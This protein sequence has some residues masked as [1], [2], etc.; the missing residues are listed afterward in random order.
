MDNSA[1]ME[2]LK[3][4]FAECDVDNNGCLGRDEFSELCSK[5]GLNKEAAHE[6]FARLDI[7]RD[8]K[9]TFDEFAAGFNQYKSSSSSSSSPQPP[10]AATAAAGNNSPP[11]PQSRFAGGQPQQFIKKPP[12][13]ASSSRQKG[14][15]PVSVMSLGSTS[16]AAATAAATA[17][18]T[19]GNN[20][21]N[22]SNNNLLGLAAAKTV[23]SAGGSSGAS[24]DMS[25]SFNGTTGGSVDTTTHS[26]SLYSAPSSS[27]D[28][29]QQQRPPD[30][31]SMVVYSSE[32][33]GN[34]YYD[35]P[36]A[37]HSGQFG[38]LFGCGGGGGG[39][40]SL[41]GASSGSF[42]QVRNMQELLDCVQKL[43]SENQILTQIF[44]KDKREREEYISQLGEEFDQQVREVEE[45]A[46]RRAREELE[47]EKKRLRE[48]MQTE[49][50]TLQHHYKT[51]EKMSKLIQNPSS[52]RSSNDL[53][54]GGEG[55]DKVKSKLEDTYLENRQLKRSLLDTKT[56]VAMIWKEMEK[57]KSQYEDKLSSAY[58]K[59]NETRSE[60]DHIKQQLNLMKDSNR[61]LQDASDVITT[62]I[63]D[64]VDPV[65]K[66]ASAAGA[67]SE[68]EHYL[69]SPNGCHSL[70]GG[71]TSGASQS[72]SRRGSVL[73]EYL[74]SHPASSESDEDDDNDND[75]DGD[76]EGDD[77]DENDKGRRFGSK[78]QQQ[79]RRGELA[80]IPGGNPD[81]TEYDARS[82]TASS[83]MRTSGG[84]PKISLPA[85]GSEQQLNDAAAGR[86]MKKSS[87]FNPLTSS[88]EAAAGKSREDAGRKT[89][90]TPEPESEAT[91]EAARAKLQTS[92]SQMETLSTSSSRGSSLKNLG[93]HFFL[94]SKDKLAGCASTGQS[95]SGQSDS[96]LTPKA[97]S[98]SLDQR[99]ALEPV[100]EPADGPS[101]STF[102]II[103]VG[104]SFVGK[105]SFAARFMEGNFVQG[106]ISNC[107]IDFKTK[108][109]K[110]DG[111]NY[112]VNLWDTAGQERFRSI[113]ASYFRKADGIIL[114]YDVTD[115]R[116]YLNVRNWMSTISDTAA[117]N[118][119]VLLVGNKIDLRL[120]KNKD[121]CVPHAE[122]FRLAK[123]YDI[124]FLET[125]VKT[126][127]NLVP[128]MGR[129]I[130]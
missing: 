17:T 123:E 39:G 93:R 73:S 44:F 10:A 84:L 37:G 14:A 28:H 68:S 20:S 43:Q 46:N 63:T 117:E 80:T 45:R 126:G 112:T 41:N 25:D 50:E 57:L 33:T 109:Y 79:Q 58:L 82:T 99:D 127:T 36:T 75:D 60:C 83:S 38:S 122:G 94:G 95:Q 19:S 125:S 24:A 51:I 2:N 35:Q 118:V 90:N 97:K 40:G 21:S 100:V 5:I 105:S 30:D 111:V 66:G 113:T 106:L 32:S 22:S 120:E 110:V 34:D 102:N 72:N 52:S 103:L 114:M 59:N 119:A 101:V 98:M 86:Q 49:R 26:S 124:V 107:S 48:M 65:I 121:K 129:L 1:F 13:L 27:T 11:N 115:K 76:N 62:Y 116:S 47:N 18:A 89:T 67:N 88:P 12:S 8:D 91:K 42:S 23:G 9:I 15:S 130:R 74:N 31:N 96:A 87:S 108:A 70:T 128:S 4:L 6:T 53:L 77:D 3:Q 55:M 54:L 92:S 64:K 61:K 56:D 104:D 16:P 7:D 85:R 78:Q 29:Q 69:L 81:Q 71:G